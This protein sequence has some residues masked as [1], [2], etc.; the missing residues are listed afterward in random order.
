MTVVLELAD[1]TVSFPAGRERREVVRSVDLELVRG[2][3]LG[4]VGESGSGKTVILRALMGLLPGSARVSSGV[5][6]LTGTPVPLT[7]R[8]LRTARRRRLAMVFQDSLTALDPVMTVGDQIAEVPRRVFGAS[9]PAA[10]QAALQVME[11]VRLPHP[12]Q[13]AGAFPHQLSGGERQRAAIAMAL[14]CRPQILLCDEPT[15]ALDVTIQAEILQLLTDLRDTSGLSMIFVSHD[16]AVVGAMADR[17]MVMQSGRTV[18]S[19]TTAAVIRTPQ[20]PYT[21]RLLRAV[22]DLPPVVVDDAAQPPPVRTPSSTTVRIRAGH[23]VVTYG[24]GPAAIRAVDGVDLS[25]RAGRIHGL[26]GESGSGKSTLAKVLTGQVR[27]DSGSVMLDGV[28]LTL[29]RTR[30]QLS[31]VQMV[32]QDP[33]SSL[34]PRM[35]VRQILSELLRMVRGLS[36]RQVEARCAELLAQV[37]LPASALDGYPGQFSGGQRQRI[38]IARALA[39][40]PRVLV[41]DEPT[42]ALDVSIQGAVLDLLVRLRDDLG[43]AVL[44][45]SH[46]LAVIRHI[47]DDVSVMLAGTVVESGPVAQVIDHPREPYTRQLVDAVPRL[48]KDPA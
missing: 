40:E 42:S 36:R 11:L 39:V 41:A 2:S 30:S 48:R 18:E 12:E 34:D 21:R 8:G 29:P 7:G 9:K 43:L 25:V 46:N 32:Y 38:A 3:T 24:S 14:A 10:R 37:S 20:Q 4:I 19:G 28:A 31:A 45:I 6:S 15:T 26:V 16:L 47:C 44:V 1:L 13:R 22:L 27:A 35:T 33:F 23:I 5:L 17:L